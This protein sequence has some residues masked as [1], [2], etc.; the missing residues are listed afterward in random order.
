MSVDKH[1]WAEQ[2]EDWYVCAKC[3]ENLLEVER[4]RGYGSLEIKCLKCG[5]WNQAY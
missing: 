3:E 5:T 4:V 2:D 1:Y